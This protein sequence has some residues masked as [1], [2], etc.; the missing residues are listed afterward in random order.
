LRYTFLSTAALCPN[1]TRTR[2]RDSQRT[3]KLLDFFRFSTV[4]GVVDGLT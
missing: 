1:M 4:S 3:E 2:G